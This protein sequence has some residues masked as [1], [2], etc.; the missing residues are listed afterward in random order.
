MKTKSKTPA[1]LAS[2]W[3]LLLI[4][5]WLISSGCVAVSVTAPLSG[6]RAEGKNTFGTVYLT[7]GAFTRPHRVIGVVQMTQ[8]GYRWLHEQEVI[9]EANPD[10]VLYRIGT[11]VRQQGADGIQ[12]LILIDQN[13]QTSEE[14]TARQISTAIRIINQINRGEPPTA[15]GEGT[16]TKYM[17]KGEL[18]K[19][20]D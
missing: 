20:L 4:G 13:P 10:S 12:H 8:K 19:F 17:V 18:V 3:I 1:F 14:K 9:S 11:Y 15:L 7:S 2:W 16:E 5:C 6:D